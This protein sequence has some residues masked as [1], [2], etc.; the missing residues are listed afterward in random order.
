VLLSLVVLAASACGSRVPVDPVTGLPLSEPTTSSA[1]TEPAP[2]G[3][4]DAVPR[5]TPTA[6]STATAPTSGGAPTGQAAPGSGPAPGAGTEPSAE[7]TGEQPPPADVPMRRPGTYTYDTS[8]STSTSFTG[9]RELPPETTLT[10]RPADGATQVSVRDMRGEEG[11][12]SVTE[13]TL[14]FSTEGVSLARLKVTT[15]VSEGFTDERE[16]VLDPPE[17]IATPNAAPGDRLTFTMDD[18]ETRADVTI[19]VLREEALTIGGTEAV[20]VVARTTTQLSGQVEGE[21]V[22]TSWIRREDFLPIREEGS[23]DVRSGPVRAQGNY[24]AQ[25]RSLDPA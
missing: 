16:W 10:V 1:S 22:T 6:T 12:G 23:S 7:P 17:L 24:D 5:A 15:V 11:R 8:G 18:G 9:E 19:E 21:Q 2:T 3:G 20:T 13:S 25:L 14:V 4:P